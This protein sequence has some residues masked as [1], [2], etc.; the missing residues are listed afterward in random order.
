[1]PPKA[2]KGDVKKPSGGVRG[3]SAEEKSRRMLE[4]FKSAEVYS[5]KELEKLGA[6]KGVLSQV[7]PD[8]VKGLV[9][10]GL[11]DMDKIGGGNFFWALPSKQGQRKKARLDVLKKD[12]GTAQ[13]VIAKEKARTATLSS[14]RTPSQDRTTNL[15]H[16]SQLE[17]LEDELKEK[18]KHYEDRDPTVLR[19][20]GEKV[21]FAMEGACRWGSNLAIIREYVQD[22][23]GMDEEVFD[24]R[25]ELGKMDLQPITWQTYKNF[26]PAE[27]APLVRK[28]QDDDFPPESTTENKESEA[29]TL[30]APDP[31]HTATPKPTVAVTPIVT[32][33]FGKCVIS[34]SVAVAPS[35]EAKGESS[36]IS[37]AVPKKAA[38][39]AAPKKPAASG[40]KEAAITNSQG[41][42]QEEPSTAGKNKG[43]K[44]ATEKK[45]P[46]EK[47][48]KKKPAEKKSKIVE[49]SEDKASQSVVKPPQ[50]AQLAAAAD[51]LADVTPVT[52]GEG[53]EGAAGAGELAKKS[54]SH[55]GKTTRQSCVEEETSKR[56]C[57][58]GNR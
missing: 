1:M 37:A 29:T 24:G 7:I 4:I 30:S 36:K 18:L 44:K 5:M 2:P 50:P 38:K 39:K 25:Y 42:M 49:N 35:T 14:E 15:K 55:G 32:L 16:F 57:N 13:S 20:L 9:D 51:K 45:Q 11:V 19:A 17:R 10:D 41:D 53:V 26:F 33:S 27:G 46:G 12:L 40:E 54:E 58:G 43:A 47:K 28:V 3:V 21:T 31:Q 6:K 8:V 52:E 22:E 56:D 34:S 48:D 23:T